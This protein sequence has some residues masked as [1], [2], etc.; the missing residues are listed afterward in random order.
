MKNF[1]VYVFLVFCV[2]MDVKA[3]QSPAVNDSLLLDYYQNQRFAEAADYLKKTYPEPI[4]NS[5]VLSK[6][7]Y[8]SQMASRLTDAEAYYQRMYQADSTNTTV[9]FSLGAINLRRGNNPKAETYYKMIARK[10]STN[11]LV[12]K[13]LGKIAEDKADVAAML[14]YLQKANKINSADPDV[15]SDLSDLFVNLKQYPAAEKALNGAIIKDPENVIL[16]QSLL[17]LTSAQ[18]KFAATRDICLRMIDL[19]VRSGYVLTKLGVAYYNLKNYTCSVETFADIPGLEQSET[20]FYVA[21]LAYKALKDQPM[22][23]INLHNAITEGI[24]GNISDYYAE[25]ADSYEVSRKYK[26]A[27]MAYQKSLQFAEKPI[28]YYLL[29][30]L[31]DTDLKN[32]Q[33]ALKYYKKYM[34]S[35]PP[36][37]EQKYMAYSKSRLS[38]LAR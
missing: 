3:Q 32:K 16:L 30:S 21:S 37:K 11:F 8:T 12:Y 25:M 24:S 7:A 29:A 10:D 13:Q 28:I 34:Q 23:I 6:L 1:V 19:G 2:S 27:A 35:K 15:A 4:T 14:S 33:L 36:V 20:S 38:E 31:Y 5:R 26:K 9:L 18:D 17:K 22:A